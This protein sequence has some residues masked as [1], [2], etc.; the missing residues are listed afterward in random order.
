MWYLTVFTYSRVDPRRLP[1]DLYTTIFQH[2]KC[3][4]IKICIFWILKLHIDTHVCE[5]HTYFTQKHFQT[6]HPPVRLLAHIKEYNKHGCQSLLNFAIKSENKPLLSKWTANSDQNWYLTK[7]GRISV[8]ERGKK[9]LVT[10]SHFSF[11]FIHS[12]TFLFHF[13]SSSCKYFTLQSFSFFSWI[14]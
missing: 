6:W 1:D 5:I 3:I 9:L 14:I 2:F 8:R 13:D 12:F 11:I 4:I 7:T 10:V